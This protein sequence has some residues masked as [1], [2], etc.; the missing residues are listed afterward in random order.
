MD[1]VRCPRCAKQIPSFSRFCGR[2]G[3]AVSRTG[4]FGMQ[5]TP[6]PPMADDRTEPAASP[7]T[8]PSRPPPKPASGMGTFIFILIAI[9]TALMV[10]S[11]RRTARPRS[12]PPPV[13]FYQPSPRERLNYAPWQFQ[14]ERRGSGRIAASIDIPPAPSRRQTKRPQLTISDEVIDRIIRKASQYLDRIEAD[15]GAIHKSAVA[16]DDGMVP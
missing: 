5:A 10:M 11:S 7:G 16:H 6:L 3:C 14:I 9:V 1:M 15:R 13:R 12:A 8:R 4:G 2:C